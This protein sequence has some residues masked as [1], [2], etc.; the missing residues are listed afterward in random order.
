MSLDRG[1]EPGIMQVF[2]MNIS[3]DF[4]DLKKQ[5]EIKILSL[6]DEEFKMDKL[7]FKIKHYN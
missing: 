6:Y 4:D 5:H 3:I 7:D 1:V 2:D